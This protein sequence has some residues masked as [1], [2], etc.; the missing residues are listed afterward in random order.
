M[1]SSSLTVLDLIPKR[2]EA[3]TRAIF[4]AF[5]NIKSQTFSD[6]S[7]DVGQAEGGRGA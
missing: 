4:Q 6:A 5:E 2:E 1:T 3:Y 7:C